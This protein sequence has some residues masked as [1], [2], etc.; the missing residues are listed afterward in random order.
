M[1]KFIDTNI[2]LSHLDVLE[3]E[4]MFLISSVSI[5]EL[6]EIKTNSKK[7][8]EL[9]YSA[10]VAVR[11]LNDH[12]EKYKAIIYDG[13]VRD[14]NDHLLDE[15]HDTQIV[16]CATYAKSVMGYGDLIFIT[17]DILC[18][19]IAKEY[20]GLAVDS[21]KSNADD[22]YMGFIEKIL[23]EPEIAWFY[24]HLSENIYGL[25]INEYI[26]L[27]NEL[28]E[29]IDIYRWTGEEYEGL[30]KKP[31]KSASFGDKLKA[32]DVY[33]Q[34]AI[35]SLIKNTM[36][37]ISGKAGS[38]KSLLSLMVAMHLIESGKYDR[39]VILYNPIKLRGSE[40]QGY[41]PG[42]ATEKAMQSG[43]GQI[44][45]TKFGDRL[46]VD[47][48]INQDK[49]K[50]VCMSDCRGMEIRD[51]EILWITE[52]E[53]TSIDLIKICLSRVSSGA[54]V[55][56]EGDFEQ[57]DSVHFQGEK[58]GMK[59]AI[60]VFKDHGEFGYVQLQNVWRSRIA[61]LCDLL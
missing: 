48:L 20:F 41:Y 47:L 29:V 46:G 31:I 58:N 52:C 14:F 30:Y 25:F 37:A 33:Q 9:R 44:L 17:D 57:I 51:N 50:L 59:R 56:I 6:E 42:S 61:E 45:T 43:I 24:E 5:Q 12:P 40:N 8:E 22:A 7:T 54:K 35:D 36:T 21:L 39:L 18:K 23:S 34:M 32:K 10:R 15:T 53:N 3:N 4:N 49:I 16:E 1:T 11:W 60:D 26:V 28:N 19:L 2:L 55:F 38:G 13:E 27:K